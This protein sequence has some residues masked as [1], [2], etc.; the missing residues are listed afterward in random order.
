MNN[1]DSQGIL[2]LSM[3]DV[4]RREGASLIARQIELENMKMRQY[5]AKEKVN[6]RNVSLRQDKKMID[7]LSRIS[8]EHESVEQWQMNFKKQ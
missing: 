2:D 3:G 4:R 6:E 1:S 7:Y 8:Q 5:N